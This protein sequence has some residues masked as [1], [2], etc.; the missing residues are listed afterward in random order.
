MIGNLQ[1]FF[2][3]PA[4]TDA[5]FKEALAVPLKQKEVILKA[6]AKKYTKF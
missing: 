2:N 1:M 4:S 3:I 6:T 5:V